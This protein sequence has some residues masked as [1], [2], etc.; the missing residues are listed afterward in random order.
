MVSQERFKLPPS[1][2]ATQHGWGSRL[3]AETAS[4]PALGLDVQFLQPAVKGVS[5]NLFLSNCDDAS[6]VLRLRVHELTLPSSPVQ[7][8]ALLLLTPSNLQLGVSG[9]RGRCSRVAGGR[10]AA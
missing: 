7:R 5:S 6:T 8:Q 3:N 1:S 2:K 4:L 9:R 10:M